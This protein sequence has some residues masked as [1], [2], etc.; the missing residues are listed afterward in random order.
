MVSLT[1]L[2]LIGQRFEIDVIT[3]DLEVKRRFHNGRC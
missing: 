2:L 1:W 3:E